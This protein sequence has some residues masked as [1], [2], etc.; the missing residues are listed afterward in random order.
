MRVELTERQITEYRAAK[1]GQRQRLAEEWNIPY[2]SLRGAM[3]R[4]G[5]TQ[6]DERP[7]DGW[8]EL[9]ERAG[10]NADRPGLTEC[11]KPIVMVE[12]PKP[13]KLTKWL[14]AADQHAPLHDDT[15]IE[16]L[17]R[18]AYHEEVEDLVIGGDFFDLAELS[19]H[20]DDI[21]MPDINQ[22]LEIAGQVLRYI[23]SNVKTVYILP[24]NHCRRLAKRLNKNLSFH[25]L[26]RMAVGALEGIATTENDYF[27]INESTPERPGWSVGHPKFFAAYPTKG[28]D[29]VAL[30]RQRHVIGAHS[31][32]LGATKIGR[33][34]CISPG[35]MMRQD[36]TPYLV[37]SNGLSKHPDQ[38][39]GFVL[40]ESTR[41]GDMFRLFSEG[42]T[43]WPD[44]L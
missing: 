9:R 25:N 10:L 41:E 21:P 37:R 12:E 30:Q 29:V 15:W 34:W 23:K 36:L 38:A 8:P 35:M 42:T 31:H 39:H 11:P 28:L 6:A 18:V 1:H 14:Y 2:N 19:A 33:Y 27:L 24:G 20:G 40:V 16:R 44:Y 3:S 43:Y 5:T 22:S 7:L 32:T 13:L 17:C 26:V 4:L